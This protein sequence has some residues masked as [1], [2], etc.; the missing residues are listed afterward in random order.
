MYCAIGDK[1]IGKDKGLLFALLA[2]V[3]ILGFLNHAIDI[4][5]VLLV[6]L[7]FLMIWLGVYK[8]EILVKYFLIHFSW[9]WGIVDVFLLDTFP[10]WVPNLQMFSYHTGALFWLILSYFVFIVFLCYF[11]S[12]HSRN[13]SS[14][15]CRHKFDTSKN[16]IYMLIMILA[17]ALLLVSLV[18]AY[19]TGYFTSGASSRFAYMASADTFSLSYS[20]LFIMFVPVVSI[21]A[22]VNKAPR[23]VYVFVGMYLV[24]LLFVGNKFGALIQVIWIFVIS[25]FLVSVNTRRDMKTMTSKLLISFVILLCVFGVYSVFQMFLEHGNLSAA[26]QQFTNR[27]SNGQGDIWWGIY[28][29]YSS[30]A[31]HLYEIADEL[32]AFSTPGGSQ[33]NYN[34]AIYKMMNLIAPQSILEAYASIGA[35]FTSSTPASLYY[36]FGLSG[37][38]LGQ[39]FL[40]WLLSFIVNRLILACRSCYGLDAFLWTWLLTHALRINS[41]SEFYLVF[42]RTFLVCA[43]VLLILHIYRKDKSGSSSIGNRSSANSMNSPDRQISERHNLFP[44]KAQFDNLFENASNYNKRRRFNK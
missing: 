31:P 29:R 16:R 20:A 9:C 41:M 28:A 23:I 19:R 32:Q 22:R 39:I 33:L 43:L 25:Y 4:N 5:V 40:A 13:V 2:L 10:S 27:L 1:R 26:F 37:L 38:I 24:Y 3:A 12:K 30:G 7:V 18:D 11:D 36:Y 14:K 15:S 21:F 34:F 44:K 42:T 6:A 8:C 35:R 17:I